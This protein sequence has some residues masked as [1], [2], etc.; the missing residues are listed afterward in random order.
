V[1]GIGFRGQAEV[2]SLREALDAAIAKAGGGKVDAL[3]TEAAKAR[4]PVFRDLAQALGVPGLGVSIEDLGAM[5]TPTQSARV[6]DM[7][8]TGSLAEA[9]ALVAAGPGAR[10]VAERVVS[11][12]GMGTAAIATDEGTD[13]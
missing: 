13:G 3:V 4:T 6:S 11:Q 5:I 2:A 8:G 7:F 9:A 12:D 10:L 1:A